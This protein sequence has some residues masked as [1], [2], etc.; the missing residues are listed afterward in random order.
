MGWNCGNCTELDWNENPICLKVT[1]SNVRNRSNRSEMA[2]YDDQRYLGDE[3]RKLSPNSGQTFAN[4]D[5]NG[6]ME[7]RRCIRLMSEITKCN[8]HVDLDELLTAYGTGMD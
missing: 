7:I 4:N 8:D 5:S 2:I 3:R 1:V 6:L